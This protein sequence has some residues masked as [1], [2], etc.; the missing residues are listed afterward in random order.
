MFLENSV[1][2]RMWEIANTVFFISMQGSNI[3]TDIA[4]QQY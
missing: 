2:P 4:L 3:R 1:F